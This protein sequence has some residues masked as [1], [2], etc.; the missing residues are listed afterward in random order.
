M[1]IFTKYNRNSINDRQIDTLI[2]LAKG[3]CAN[4]NVDQAEAEVLLSWLIQNAGSEN[5]MIT[6][7]LAKVSAMLDDE[8]LDDD[9]AIEL[10]SILRSVAGEDGEIGEVAKPATLPLCTPPPQLEFN[11]KTFLL[12]GTFAYG[13][14]SQCH[15]VIEGMGGKTIKSITKSLD[16]LVIGSYVTSSWSHESFGRKIEKAMEYR[17]SGLPI[18]IISEEHWLKEAGL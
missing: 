8:H 1:D 10:F 13:T 17:E 11:N 7:L 9:E 14:R 4:G 16:Y 6:N 12:T 5:G 18:S 15:A 3:I 2:G